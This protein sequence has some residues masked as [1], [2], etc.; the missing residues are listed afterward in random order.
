MCPIKIRVDV[1]EVVSF[2]FEGAIFIAPLNVNV[3]ISLTSTIVFTG[4]NNSANFRTTYYL[5]GNS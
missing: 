5:F 2:T 1:S 3:A 4:D